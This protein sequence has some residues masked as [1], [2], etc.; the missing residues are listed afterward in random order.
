MS[1]CRCVVC[2]TVHSAAEDVSG[3]S[4]ESAVTK[5]QP[6]LLG[7]ANEKNL[8]F[9]AGFAVL[10]LTETGLEAA[11]QGLEVSHATGARGATTN[12][13]GG[14]VVC[15]RRAKSGRSVTGIL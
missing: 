10:T 7:F 13:L 5:S 9:H 1:S 6:V 15:G 12:S 3:Y 14:P 8:V 2:E 11:G 4:D